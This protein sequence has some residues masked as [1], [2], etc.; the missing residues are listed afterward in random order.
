MTDHRAIAER[1][2]R[3]CERGDFDAARSHLAEDFV[4]VYPG[5]VRYGD[6]EA[7][8]SHTANL[9]RDIEYVFDGWTVGE[10]LD[11][12]RSCA[13]W[14]TLAGENLNGVAFSGVRFIEVF[15]F[16]GE[17]IA[18]LHACNDLAVSGVVTALPPDSDTP[19]TSS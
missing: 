16:D 12:R 7:R 9:Y 17:R 6:P 5:N 1:Y 2:V 14:G 19:E 4:M 15:I 11:G 3:A 10:A 18:E 8:A 13:S